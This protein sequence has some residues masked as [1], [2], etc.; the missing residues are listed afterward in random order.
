MGR[1]QHDGTNLAVYNKEKGNYHTITLLE[2]AEGWMTE[3]KKKAVKKQKLLSLIGDTLYINN[4]FVKCA[5]LKLS[6]RWKTI[7]I[8]I[9]FRNF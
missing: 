5:L 1:W 8:R 3:K 4:L 7:S 6:G 9:E 2:R